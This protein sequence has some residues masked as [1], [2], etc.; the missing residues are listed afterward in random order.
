MLAELQPHPD[1]P[2]AAIESLDIELRR[3]AGGM[4]SLTWRI[5]GSVDVLRIP[6]PAAAIRTDDLWRHMCFE[7]FVHTAGEGYREYNLSPSSAW[8]AYAFQAYRGGM[9]AL[10]CA[11]PPIET[12]SSP[13]MFEL[14]ASID[15]ADLPAGPARRIGLSAVIEDRDGALSYWAL[16]HPP[17][18]PDFH[19]EDCFALQLP[20]AG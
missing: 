15:L 4:L 12:R 14:H 9:T 8:A 11:A 17:G 10:S 3:S 20:P 16:A 5:L 2:C 13:D 18:R 19:H 6:D 1:T 7:T